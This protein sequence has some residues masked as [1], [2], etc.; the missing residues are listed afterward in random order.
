MEPLVDAPLFVQIATRIRHQIARGRLKVG[1]QLPSLRPAASLW[2]VNL[3][4]VRRAYDYLQTQGLV[5]TRH[6]SGTFVSLEANTEL[7]DDDQL[8]AFVSW[9]A[10]TALKRFG[11]HPAEVGEM[12]TARET[13]SES[14]WVLE[15][16]E[17]L[18][19]SLAEQIRAWSPGLDVRPW[20]VKDAGAVPPG[21]VLATYYHHAE[22]RRANSGHRPPA[23]FFRVELDE[24]HL[25][26]VCEHGR[27]PVT[28]LA[29]EAATGA[30]LAHEVE[31]ML[32][33]TIGVDLRVTRDPAQVLANASEDLPVLVSPENWDRLDEETRNRRGIFPVLLRPNLDDLERILAPALPLE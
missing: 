1:D 24:E 3:H 7:D 26:T 2:G 29:A 11:A 33:E 4:T 15:C 9:V 14:V 19:E 10:E 28:L 16:S 30:A 13:E 5:E 32:G 8:I 6:G 21:R 22:V 25:H 17:S 20:L 31:E 23:A 27:K 18:A 12:L